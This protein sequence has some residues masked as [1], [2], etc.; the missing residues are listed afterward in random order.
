MRLIL[1][2]IYRILPTSWRNFMQL[3]RLRLLHKGKQCHI[4]SPYISIG[5]RLSDNVNIPRGCIIYENVTIGRYTYMQRDCEINNASIGNF[6]SLG[7]NV[8]IGPFEHNICLTS[9]SPKVYRNVLGG[10]YFDTPKHTVIGNDVW[11]GS[12]VIILDGVTVGDGAVIGAGSVV[13]KDVPPYSIV[14]GNPARVI[15]YRFDDEK[16]KEL[17]ESDW[18]HWND[19]SIKESK[20]FK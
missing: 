9:L 8:L 18:Y 13:T 6:C 2:S 19:N 1:G 14:V 11:I 12:Y 7:S 5:A 3:M 20:L 4:N 10:G 15:K 16:I 17:I